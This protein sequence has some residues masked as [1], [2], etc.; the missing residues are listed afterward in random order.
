MACSPPDRYCAVLYFSK[1]TP[2][3]PPGMRVPN[4]V[5]LYDPGY[6]DWGGKLRP[7]EP[8]IRFQ[9]PADYISIMGDNPADVMMVFFCSYP[10]LKIDPMA[11]DADFHNSGA[12]VQQDGSFPTSPGGN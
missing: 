7:T 11:T 6:C 3:E 9:H 5:A 1:T 10:E 8:L 4:H 12:Q 2:P